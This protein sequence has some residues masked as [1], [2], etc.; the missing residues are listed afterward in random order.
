MTLFTWLF[1]ENNHIIL[2]VI[3]LVQTITMNTHNSFFQLR[4]D[5]LRFLNFVHWTMTFAFTL[6][7]TP[8]GFSKISSW[9]NVLTCF[10]HQ[11]TTD[12]VKMCLLD[13]A[14][15]WIK[16]WVYVIIHQINWLHSCTIDINCYTLY[17]IVYYYNEYTQFFFPT[18]VRHLAVS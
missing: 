4:W 8:S 9:I 18:P 17:F 1:I 14:Q 12:S 3:Q 11:N 16:P 6:G 13:P 5:I 10:L 7:A 15:I 2:S